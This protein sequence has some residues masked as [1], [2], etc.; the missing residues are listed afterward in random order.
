MSEPELLLERQGSLGLITL[1]RPKALNALNLNMI[2]TLTPQLAAWARDP[3]ITAV[4]IEGA[5]EKAFC[6]GGDVRAVY[7][8][9]LAMKRGVAGAGALTR[10][11]F[12]EEYQLNAAIKFFPK[13]YIALLNGITM[14]GGIGLSAHGSHRIVTENALLAM[15]ETGIGL[16]P[17]VGGTYLLSRAPD[18]LGTYAALAGA[19]LS[20]DDAILIGLATHKIPAAALPNLTDN[21]AGG[22][23]VESALAAFAVDANASCPLALHRAAIRT[24]FAPAAVEEIIKSLA[25]DP[26]EWAQKTAAQLKTLSPT[27]LKVTHEALRRAKTLSFAECLKMEYRLSQACMARHDFYEGIRA[28]LVDKDKAPR[29]NPSRLEDVDESMV[30]AHF[31]EPAAGDL[32]LAA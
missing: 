26:A 31:A 24:H 6:A 23:P 12:Y 19:R 3:A 15:P 21:L 16:F 18:H 29:W 7:E 20:A 9:G 11:F 4:L 27:S 17:D 30:A 22:Q 32:A 10:E 25:A 13:P 5:G 8:D 14:G 28:L 1:N 2:R